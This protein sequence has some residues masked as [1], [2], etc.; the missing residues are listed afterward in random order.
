MSICSVRKFS[1]ADVRRRVRDVDRERVLAGAEVRRPLVERGRGRRLGLDA[2][3]EALHRRAVGRSCAR[4]AAAR[5]P[6]WGAGRSGRSLEPSSS[7]TSSE[8]GRVSLHPSDG[9]RAGR[10]DVHEHVARAVAWWSRRFC[11]LPVNENGNVSSMLQSRSTDFGLP[12]HCRSDDLVRAVL[13]RRPEAGPADPHH[14]VA[15]VG[16][17][18]T[19]RRRVRRVRRRSGRR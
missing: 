8:H 16:R 5:S 15:E 4:T 17:G 7:Y 14:L 6:G 11:R 18:L 13:L 3:V 12:L 1:R 10:H 9:R 2:H 19:P